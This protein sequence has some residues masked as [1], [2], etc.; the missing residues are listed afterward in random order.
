MLKPA[1]LLTTGL[2]T[3]ALLNGG[4][5]KTHS[6]LPSP[7]TIPSGQTLQVLSFPGYFAPNTLARFESAYR[8]FFNPIRWTSLGLAVCEAFLI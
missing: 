3:A 4:C 6:P 8:F 5:Q 7:T 2:L 1:G